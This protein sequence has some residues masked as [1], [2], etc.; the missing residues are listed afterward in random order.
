MANTCFH[1][2]IYV[3]TYVHRSSP[4]TLSL[5]SETSLTSSSIF[6]N[7]CFGFFFLL[8]ASVFTHTIIFVNNLSRNL[9]KK[10]VIRIS[11]DGTN[12][13]GGVSYISPWYSLSKMEQLQTNFDLEISYEFSTLITYIRRLWIY[14]CIYLLIWGNEM[15]FAYFTFVSRILYYSHNIF[16]FTLIRDRYVHTNERIIYIRIYE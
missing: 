16:C 12:L 11:A 3:D 6:K 2:N 15:T 4:S 5:P 8:C 9:K 14:E 7:W 13:K 10:Y 1:V